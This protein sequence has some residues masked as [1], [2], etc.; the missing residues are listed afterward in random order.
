KSIA[1]FLSLIL[2]IYGIQKFYLG[3]I[4]KGIL[5]IV[6]CWTLIP[7]LIGLSD[8]FNFLFMKKENFSNKYNS[9]VNPKEI[10]KK[11]E[12][13]NS[14]KKNNSTFIEKNMESKEALK[15]Q[16]LKDEIE[17]LIKNLISVETETSN[18]S[19]IDVNAEDVDLS[20]DAD[21]EVNDNN[22]NIPPYWRHSYIYSF[23]EIETATKAQKNY[24][25]YFKSQV[26]K[27]EF[28]D[29]N[30]YTNYAFILYFDM[31]NEYNTHNDI[32][33]LEQEFTLLGKVC[34]QTKRYLFR[35]LK[36]EYM[37]R[38]DEYSKAKRRDFLDESYLF[39]NGFI[40]YN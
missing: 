25:N 12:S 16:E 32:Q 24:Y 29:I 9:K 15:A 10:K 19:I 26:L 27:G 34:R 20:I 17:T 37:Q 6:F 33:Q 35:F 36:S 30:G 13:T 40:N 4:K 2:G 5:S 39:A 38:D 21:I 11:P 18:N 14:I 8:F 23:G 3:E 28:V 7:L 22:F 1:A 31:I